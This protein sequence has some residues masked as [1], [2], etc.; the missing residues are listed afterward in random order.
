MSG[1]K[2]EGSHKFLH[3]VVCNRCGHKEA[4]SAA[5]FALMRPHIADHVAAESPV[6]GTPDGA[7]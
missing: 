6:Q 1:R 7:Q 2:V 4:W 3:M 5:G